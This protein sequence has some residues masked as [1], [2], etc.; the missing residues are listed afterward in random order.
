MEGIGGRRVFRSQLEQVRVE[1]G[2]GIE[3]VLVGRR[4]REG[5]VYLYMTLLVAYISKKANRSGQILIHKLLHITSLRRL[6]L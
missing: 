3:C 6:L 5:G 2:V 1:V 4:G